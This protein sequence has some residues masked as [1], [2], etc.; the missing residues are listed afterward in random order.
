V[1]PLLDSLVLEASLRA[2]RLLIETCSLPSPELTST[3]RLACH[4]YGIVRLE[5]LH[6]RWPPFARWIGAQDPKRRAILEVGVK[7]WLTEI[8]TSLPGRTPERRV[9]EERIAAPRPHRGVPSTRDDVTTWASVQGLE[10]MLQRPLRSLAGVF[11]S[12]RFHPLPPDILAVDVFEPASPIFRA[13]GCGPRD[14]V[15]VRQAVQ[16][17][18]LEMA[19]ARDTER[20]L[21]VIFSAHALTSLSPPAQRLDE[22]LAA[23][24]AT[25]PA[26]DPAYRA[27]PAGHVVFRPGP[28]P[29]LDVAFLSPSADRQTMPAELLVA[30]GIEGAGAA[31]GIGSALGLTTSARTA[32][33]VGHLRD[34]LR[35]AHSASAIAFRS[36]LDVPA[37]QRTL[38]RFDELST[39]RLARVEGSGD[40]LV[41][42]L[43][44]RG[45]AGVEVQIVAQAAKKNG[46]GFTLGRKV[47]PATARLLA[48]T[49]LEQRICETLTEIDFGAGYLTG[50]TRGRLQI[51]LLTLL[52]E[53]PHVSL[54]DRG[55]DRPAQ[56]RIARLETHVVAGAAGST[57]SFGVNGKRVAARDLLGAAL[58]PETS[59]W[60]DRTDATLTLV[61]FG[62]S[63]ADLLTAVAEQPALFPLEATD[64][65]LALLERLQDSVDVVV[66]PDLEGTPVDAD[67]RPHV[68][69]EVAG[70]GDEGLSLT[71]GVRPIEGGPLLLPGEGGARVFGQGATGRV[72]ARRDQAKER[73][74]CEALREALLPAAPKS[75]T[76]EGAW[77]VRI[78][79]PDGALELLLALSERSDVV[80]E[81]GSTKPPSIVRVST[82]EVRLRVTKQRDW[83]GIDGGVELDEVRV[84][85]AALLAAAR[86][87]RRFV[88]VDKDKIVAIADDLRQR[89]RALDDAV[90]VDRK[91]LVQADALALPAVEGLVTEPRALVAAKE[92]VA[93]RERRR[94][95]ETFEPVLPKG[96]KAVLRPYQSEGFAWMA[97]LA[98]WSDGAC[99]ADDMGLGKTVQTLAF[100]LHRKATGP[101]LVLAPTSVVANWVAEAARFAPSL[102]V[103]SYRGPGR[104]ALLAKLRAGDVVVCSYDI[105]VRDIVA[106]EE[107]SFGTLVLDEAQAVKNAASRRAGA[108]ADLHADFRLALSGTPIENHLGELWSLYHAVS[109]GL[110]GSWER[111]RERFAQP[112]ER[113]KNPERSRALAAL[114]RPFLLRRTKEAVAPELPA[115]TETVRTVKL[116]SAERERYETERLASIDVIRKAD[117]L[118]GRF[119]MLA[120]ITR[121][122]RLA[123]N[124]RLVDESARIPSTKLAAF[125]ATV[126]EIREAGHRAL[127]FSQFTS[128]LALVREALDARRVSYQYLDGQTPAEERQVR[129]DAFQA[130]Q[131][132]LFLLSLK[133]GGT[134]LNLTGADYVLHLDP[135]WN[136][137]VEDQ[138]T[139][140]AHRIGQTKP[141]TVVRFVAEGTIEEGVLAMHAEKRELADSLLAGGELA[142]TLNSKQ[143]LALVRAGEAAMVDE[144]D[145]EDDGED[146]DE[147]DGDDEE[148]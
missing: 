142:A 80:V 129:V 108:L 143:L 49:T 63:G 104:A 128:H 2:P 94:A 122:R 17:V 79:D 136:P 117:P 85:L 139:D 134:G 61:R 109:P 84:G 55:E 28:P 137:A 37:W 90:T 3:F 75:F 32:A 31:A 22:A 60:V 82:K 73:L 29:S 123:C 58:D 132:D 7:V 102:R 105:M 67:T 125:L 39:S 53:H 48:T 9:L 114:V 69:I 121:L 54:V 92:W 59:L 19:S 23:W 144:A 68:R 47:P 42:K 33:I 27:Y 38:A 81:H 141:V 88:R 51:A 111:F 52:S 127:V 41:F 133:A 103:R 72:V 95:A 4:A 118:T 24:A 6:A 99:L 62:A 36:W 83:F 93:L 140:R 16:Q 5:D 131:G 78:G 100:L 101:A 64:Q 1:D 13:H 107:V 56:V 77:S 30:G 21:R 65:L 115:L 12:A 35:D 113:D 70:S 119:A 135:W 124:V 57:L 14:L 40:R 116:S 126:E 46:G 110:F 44:L 34:F 87:G 98:A 66:P 112:I 74:V 145:D 15:P 89:L 147:G 18:L 11:W 97:R 8:T 76:R 120:A 43:L 130:G 146:E 86:S 10:E 148:G 106:L 138:A 25:L 20:V 96:L 91:G 71:I 45:K 26:P 50:A